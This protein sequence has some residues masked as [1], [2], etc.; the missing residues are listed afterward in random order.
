MKEIESVECC[1]SILREEEY[2]LLIARVA[3]HYLKDKVRSKTEL[4]G[5]VNRLLISRQLEPVSFGFIRNNV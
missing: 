3:V 5:E 4:Y 2:R 1:R